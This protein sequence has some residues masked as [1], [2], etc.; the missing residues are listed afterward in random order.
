M[1]WSGHKR[2]TLVMEIASS[3]EWDLLVAGSK[4]EIRSPRPLLD[5]DTEAPTIVMLHHDGKYSPFVL[6][7]IWREELKDITDGDAQAE[8]FDS[9]AAFK[10]HWCSK[11]G[12]IHFSPLERVW[13]YEFDSEWDPACFMVDCMKPGME[14]N[15]S[16]EAV[17]GLIESLYP[18]TMR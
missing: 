5:P 7:T 4:T 17:M 16:V 9:L 1:K 14:R 3:L 11:T 2:E 6:S 8:G 15:T 12:S 13:G 10:R 18:T